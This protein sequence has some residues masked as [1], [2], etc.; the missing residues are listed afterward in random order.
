MQLGGGRWWSGIPDMS[1]AETQELVSPTPSLA[2]D[3]DFLC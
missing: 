3:G 1:G 2:L